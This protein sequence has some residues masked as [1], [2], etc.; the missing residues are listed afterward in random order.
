MYYSL[1]TGKS[2]GDIFNL[3]LDLPNDCSLCQVDTE[4]ASLVLKFFKDLKP[5]L[6]IRLL[7]A[8][9]QAQI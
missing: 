3:G 4:P 5:T 1:S 7:P 6:K 2:G 9:T 8:P